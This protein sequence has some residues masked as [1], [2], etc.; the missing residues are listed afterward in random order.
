MLQQRRIICIIELGAFILCLGIAGM[1]FLRSVQAQDLEDWA[2][3]YRPALLPDFAGDMV[4]YADAPRYVVDL[5]LDVTPDEVTITGHQL[6]CYTNRAA[7]VALETIVFRLYP[8][9][10]SY[11]GDMQVSGVMVD[12][13]PVESELDDTRSVL[14]VPLPAALEPGESATVEM[15][16]VTLVSAGVK[17]LYAQFAYLDGVIT[18][19]QAYPVLSVYQPGGGWWQATEHPQGDAIFSET[20]F[21]EVTVSAPADLILAASGSEIGLSANDD[22]T[23]S[24]RYA[25]PLMRDFTLMASAD[26]VTAVGQQ[27]GVTITL[28]YNPDLPNAAINASAGLQMAQNA[29]RIFDTVYGRYPFAELDVVQTPTTAGGIEYPGLI[30]VATEH[31]DKADDSF[32][33]I[34]A[35]EA[36]HQWWFSLVG[37]DQLLNPWMDEALAQ[38]SV[39]VYI[40]DREGLAGYNGALSFY[41]QEYSKYVAENPDMVIG[42]PV[43]AYEGS[44]YYYLVYQKGPL[45]YAALDEA[46]GYDTV[47]LMLQDYLDAYRYEIA[48][49]DDLLRSFEATLGEEL[50]PLFTEWV[51][52]YPVG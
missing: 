20:A 30:V 38:Y 18:L 29:I 7:G 51:G 21:Y 10:E 37:N 14:R 33:F 36:A 48:R 2:E 45:F 12:G 19:P 4:A 9:L 31:W 17:A 47:L 40:R 16:F 5:S 46:Y 50:D 27:D 13:V 49:P 25:A 3:V 32:E 28:Y 6:V 22:G 15:D 24:H 43:T 42:L 1:L 34:L 41:C 44:A 26:Y 23:L 35:H 8:N 52:T 11:G 39:A